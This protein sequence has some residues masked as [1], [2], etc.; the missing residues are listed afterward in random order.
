MILPCY[1]SLGPGRV[2]FVLALTFE[3]FFWQGINIVFLRIF[4]KSGINIV[5]LNLWASTTFFYHL[6]V[7]INKTLFVKIVFFYFGHQHGFQV[8]SLLSTRILL[9][10]IVIFFNFSKKNQIGPFEF[11]IHALQQC[12]W[13]LHKMLTATTTTTNC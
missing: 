11:Y 3:V 6:G 13:H 1:G 9:V 8:S 4:Q 7:D 5:F 2:R 10:K 12:R